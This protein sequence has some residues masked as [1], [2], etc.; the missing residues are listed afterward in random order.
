MGET[1]CPVIPAVSVRA[2][3]SLSD[4]PIRYEMIVRTRVIKDVEENDANRKLSAESRMSEIRI[5]NILRNTRDHEKRGKYVA[6]PTFN[7]NKATKAK[8]LINTT[9]ASSKR[10]MPKNFPKI[11]SERE[12]GFDRTI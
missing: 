8:K 9:V 6:K 10:T 12:I 3:I 5:K 7:T 2:L 4:W 1:A 11:Y